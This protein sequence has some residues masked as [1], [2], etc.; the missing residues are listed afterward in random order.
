MDIALTHAQRAM[1]ETI[2][3]LPNHWHTTS[4]KEEVKALD[5]LVTLRLIRC[6]SNM[7]RITT[8]GLA[9]LSELRGE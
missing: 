6:D 9:E 3:Q 8:Y 4:V 7:Y 1:L 5:D 2:A